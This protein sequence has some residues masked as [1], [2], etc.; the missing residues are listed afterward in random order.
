MKRKSPE[1][2]EHKAPRAKAHA[3]ASGGELLLTDFVGTYG[4]TPHSKALHIRYPHP[5]N[6]P[7]TTEGTS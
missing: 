1:A 7:I 2:V 3:V 5:L 6:N 4:T